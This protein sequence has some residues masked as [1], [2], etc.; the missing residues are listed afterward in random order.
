MHP[1]EDEELDLNKG[2]EFPLPRDFF[3]HLSEALSG[4]RMWPECWQSR[5]KSPTGRGASYLGY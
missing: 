4:T 3:R 2:V 1:K 5:I